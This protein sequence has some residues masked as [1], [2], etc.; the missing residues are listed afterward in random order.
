MRK[1]DISGSDSRRERGCAN[2][3]GGTN[4]TNPTGLEITGQLRISTL[5]GGRAC[6]R[7]VGWGEPNG[8]GYYLDLRPTGLSEKGPESE[9]ASR[10]G[11]FRGRKRWGYFSE[12]PMSSRVLFRRSN[13]S[14]H[15]SSGS[16]GFSECSISASVN[17]TSGTR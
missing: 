10:F 1:A 13:G 11:R 16:T 3:P 17:A 2:S 7:R 14:L 4:C 9:Q 5:S 12:S 6:W 8:E 15:G